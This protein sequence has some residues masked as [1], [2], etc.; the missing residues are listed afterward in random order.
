[1]KLS[2]NVPPIGLRSD[3]ITREYQ[4]EVD[5]ATDKAMVAY[6]R[7]QRR[8]RAA[9]QRLERARAARDRAGD[10]LAARNAKRELAVALELVELRRDELRRVESLMKAAPASAEHRGVRGFRPV[11]APGGAF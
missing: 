9:E 2:H 11:P 7:A 10:K 8:L 6:E 4:A 3:P 1:M 5:R